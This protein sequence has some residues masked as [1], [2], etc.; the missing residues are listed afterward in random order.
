MV[1]AGQTAVCGVYP[2]RSRRN[3][4]FYPFGG[5]RDITNTCTQNYKFEGKE[6]DTETGNDDFGARYYTSRLGRWLSADWS[7]VPAPVPYA[8][9]TNPQTLNLYAMVSDNPETFAD[10]EGHDGGT[11]TPVAGATSCATK[12]SSTPP[13]P[14]EGNTGDGTKK[15][16]TQQAQQQNNHPVHEA[17][18]VN[19]TTSPDANGNSGHVQIVYDALG[20]KLALMNGT[21]AL[22]KA[23]APLPGGATAV[24]NASGLQ[25]YRHPD[26]LGSSRF[27]STPSRTMYNDLAYA[28]F[29]EQYAAAGTTGITNVS[30]AG[31]NQDTTTNL[32]DA[33]FREY[34]IYGR[35]PSPD[36][37]GTAVAN[38]ANPQ[39]WNR[40]AYVMNNPLVSI[41]PLGLMPNHGCLVA[42]HQ[43]D[44]VPNYGNCGPPTGG[45]NCDIDGAVVPCGGGDG[46]GGGGGGFGSIQNCT[47][48]V[49]YWQSCTALYIF[50]L[51]TGTGGPG[52]GDPCGGGDCFGGGSGSPQSP[53]P[54]HI[55]T[56]KTNSQCS[57]YLQGGTTSGD[58]LNTI[59]QNTPN[60]PTFNQMRGCLQTLY[61]PTSGYI[62]LPLFILLPGGSFFDLNS[63]IPGAGAHA[64][65]AADAIQ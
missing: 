17:A 42:G 43:G 62:P 11:C 8:N 47:G 39:S 32:Y 29:G 3:A 50:S 58:L 44:G 24:Y 63:I 40:Y 4:D 27:S 28:P 48:E 25:Y 33:Q 53:I 16:T 37:A 54:Q 41:D 51:P 35:W 21:S 38:P 20:N 46:S 55:G 64:T 56:P 26:W 23:F 12:S 49:P 18:A 7:A 36:P 65:C 13:P 6:R 10:L 1:Q 57:I 22:V 31:N 52:S 5:E 15:S 14:G 30:F 2:E 45:S 61:S 9:L 19:Q 60:G 34:E 59:C